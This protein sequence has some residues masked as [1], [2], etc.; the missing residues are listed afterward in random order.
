MITYIT[1]IEYIKCVHSTVTF[2]HSVIGLRT[3]NVSPAKE[4]I[5]YSQNIPLESA[6]FYLAIFLLCGI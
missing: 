6:T 5:S 1:N 4:I 3:L 2:A